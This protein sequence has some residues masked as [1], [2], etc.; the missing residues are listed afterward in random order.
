MGCTL[1]S[2]VGAVD[3]GRSPV[4]GEVVTSFARFVERTDRNRAF[5]PLRGRLH[6]ICVDRRSRRRRRRLPRGAV[7]RPATSTAGKSPAATRA[8]TTACWCSARATASSAPT[9]GTAT[10]CSNSTGGPGATRTTTRASTSAPICRPRASPGPTATRSTSRKEPK[11]TCWASR[12]PPAADWSSRASGTTS[13]S[14]SV[15]DTAEL[16][17]NG[18]K[19]WKAAGLKNADGYIGFQSEVDGGGQFEFRNIELTDLDFKPLFNGKR[20]GRL[21]RRHQGLQ[22]R[23]RLARQPPDRRR[24]SVH[25]RGVLRFLASASTSSSSAG[26]NNGVGIR[27]PLGGDSAYEG[28]EIQILDDGDRAYNTIEPWQAHGSVYGIVP[29]KRG[30]L[31]AGRPVEPRRDHRPRPAD[32]GDP[33]RHDDRRRQSGRSQPRPARSTART[34]RA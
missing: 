10:S 6:V 11:A 22:R 24:Q 21:D 9:N 3:D 17:I 13:S 26:G 19:A 18:Q 15:G 1:P 4:V 32:H 29:A 12:G 31:E 7:Q 14:P 30:L 34:T 20:P 27:A 33:Q 2:V 5:A 28:M 8:S 25:R 23:G 16:E